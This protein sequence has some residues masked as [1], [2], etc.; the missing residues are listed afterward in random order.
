MMTVDHIQVHRQLIDPHQR[1]DAD[2]KRN[3]KS[4]DLFQV[5]PQQQQPISMYQ[6]AQ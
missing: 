3:K 1:P 6:G 4:C 5:L 2:M